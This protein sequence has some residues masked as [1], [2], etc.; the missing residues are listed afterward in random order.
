MSIFE[1]ISHDT[2]LSL[3]YIT[4][5]ARKA[6]HSY[7]HYTIPKRTGG[8]RDIYHPIPELKVI[9]HW[10]ANHIFQVLP[11]HACVY[12]YRR[13]INVAQ[14]AAAHLR[15][16]FLL[17]LDI[18]DFFPSITSKD[19]SNLLKK[20][21]K[22]IPVDL[23]PADIKTICRIVC[24][25]T[26]DSAKLRLTIGAPSSPVISNA[27]LYELDEIMFRHCEKNKVTYT[28]YADDLYFST[29]SPNI[30]SGI[31]GFVRSELKSCKS[32]KLKINPDKTVFT[33]KK[34]KRI[35]TGIT[36]T[37]SDKI[38]IGRDAKRHI[39]T[40]IYLHFSG[41]LSSEQL[42]TLRGRLC[43][44]RSV[45]PEFINALSKKYGEERIFSLIKGE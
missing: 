32:P 41:R 34:R 6:P 2:G 25:A 18:K 38:S 19:I 27:I 45:E 16:H 11:V 8:T 28:R 7:K 35:V 21:L 12:S 20:N 5:L 23:D 44:Y 39:R 26:N 33:S 15:S 10:L 40:E 22:I 17:R 42:S 24:R 36:I 3:P 29:C 31:E 14:H 13:G 1:L 30:L 43:Y 9:Q 37:S 4:K